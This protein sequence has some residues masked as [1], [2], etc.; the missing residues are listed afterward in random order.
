MNVESTSI[1]EVKV[2]EPKVFSDSRGYFFESFN[3]RSIA[4]LGISERF[5]Q[6]NHSFS[7]GG[8]L[9]GLHYQIRQ[10]QGKLIRCIRGEIFDVAV[11]LRRSSPTCGAWTSAVLSAENRRIL[12]IPQGF[13][14]GFQVLST[15]AEVLYKATDFYAPLHERTIL[16]N[17][18][19]IGIAWPGPE[20]ILSE[21]DLAGL[22][23]GAAELFD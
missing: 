16:W 23:L 4:A 3:E 9:R 15:E 18:P 11:D 12:W 17:D 5:V 2:L 21:K 19:A 8:V 13:A 20:P 14:H 22:S 6:D 1:A 10:P 7:R